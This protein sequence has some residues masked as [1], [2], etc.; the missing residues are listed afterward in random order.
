MDIA[1][2]PLA[3]DL[4]DRSIVILHGKERPH[5]QQELPCLLES[6]P[7]ILTLNCPRKAPNVHI[8][9]YFQID[10]D[11]ERKRFWLHTNDGMFGVLVW[12]QIAFGLKEPQPTDE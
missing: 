5:G 7:V 9:D 8:H 3:C 2:P 11:W 4:A 1:Y 10:G 12:G 6:H